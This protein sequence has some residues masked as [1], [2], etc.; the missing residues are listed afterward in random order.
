MR[1]WL[2]PAG[3]AVLGLGFALW[4]MAQGRFF[5]YFDNARQ[6]YAQTAFLHDALKSGYFPQWYTAVGLG[7]PAVAEGQAA[8]HFPPRVLAAYLFS[9]AAALMWEVG[10][11]LAVAGLGTYFFLREFRLIRWAAALG[12]LAQMFGA[13]SLIYVRNMALHRSLCLVPVAL[14]FTERMFR[15]GSI[16]SAAGFSVVLALQL[17]SGHPTMA[18][19]TL[20]GASVYWLTRHLQQLREQ[21]VDVPVAARRLVVAL[22]VWGVAILV[23]VGLA[24]IQV[25]PTARLAAESTRKG[26]LTFD[27]AAGNLASRLGDLFQVA[28]PYA[29]PQGDWAN[30]DSPGPPELNFVPFSNMYVGT[31]TLL[32]AWLALVYSRRW[33]KPT[34]P[35][36]A[37]CLVTTVLALGSKTPLFLLLWSMP[38]MSGMRY[39]SR[40]LLLSSFC[41]A[42]LGA[43]GLQRLTAISRRGWAPRFSGVVGLG[44]VGAVLLGAAL[45]FRQPTAV[46]GVATSLALWIVAVAVMIAIVRLKRWR[47]TIVMASVV[48]VAIDLLVFR[49]T[50][51]YAATFSLAEATGISEP[52]ASIQQDRG[53]YRTLSLL[54]LENGLIRNRELRDYVQAN[55]S[56]TW[57]IDSMDTRGSLVPLRYF[58]VR[59][60]VTWELMQ[61]APTS[62]RLRGVLGALNVKYVIGN[63]AVRLDGWEPTFAS[64]TTRV[65]KNPEA[66]PRIYVVGR[67]QPEGLQVLP[68]RRER[69]IERLA[70]YHE[71]VVDW[72]SREADAQI[73]DNILASDLDYRT[74]AVVDA[75]SWPPLSGAEPHYD[76]EDL[77]APRD[78]DSMRIRVRSDIAALLVTGNS[79]AP[80]WSATVNGH[81]VPI[82][83]TNWLLQGVFIGAGDND[84]RLTY[85]APGYQLG[86]AVSALTA[87]ILL[88]AVAVG[89]ARGWR[90]F[91][92]LRP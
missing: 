39:P 14:L 19:V 6:H 91:S 3:L 77:T 68:E 30:P 5:L 4:P 17:L 81:A 36:V 89:R 69:A 22:G 38:G 47:G 59:E 67:V 18:I 92:R 86:R 53:R 31:L 83:R 65:W 55:L 82:V 24:S 79:F 88:L 7:F 51:N 37:T 10:L 8:H 23:A 52:A 46:P 43:F 35:L 76:I 63:A 41:V 61:S 20:C 56:G 12:G 45:A 64:A 16:G 72:S 85:Q 32:L 11:Y 54:P 13:S 80:G 15:K 71:I 50:S 42:C 66:L 87:I 9:P 60:S 90:A 75:T 34:I 40:F 26:G 29:Y 21:R 33:P 28:L 62:S 73:V 25:L 44:A 74:T 48:L 78:A 1:R 57:G 70:N 27:Y 2:F 49:S 58:L 84:V